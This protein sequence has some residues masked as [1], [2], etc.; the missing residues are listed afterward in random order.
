MMRRNSFGRSLVFAALAAGFWLPWFAFV[1]PLAGGETRSLYLVAVT[2]A[3]VASIAA[4]PARAFIVGLA[5]GATGCFA[6]LLVRD[7]A[8][9]ALAL[10]A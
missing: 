5:T 7:G 6:A 3:Y 2:A 8:Q 10:A 9:L 4:S 1:A